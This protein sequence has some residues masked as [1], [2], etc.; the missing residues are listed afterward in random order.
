[1]SSSLPYK[2]PK[3]ARVHVQGEWQFIP[4]ILWPQ[5]YTAPNFER[6][7]I[8]GK[9]SAVRNLIVLFLIEAGLEKSKVAEFLE[10]SLA[11]VSTINRAMQVRLFGKNYKM[12]RV[13]IDKIIQ[14]CSSNPHADHMLELYLEKKKNYSL[15]R[16][17][18]ILAAL[19]RMGRT[20]EDEQLFHH[21]MEHLTKNGV[22]IVLDS[23]ENA[24]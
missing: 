19:S 16:M 21:A 14:Q 18:A 11:R 3:S 12:H 24:L 20:M 1:M 2:E 22:K 6:W 9:E 7:R 8:H 15:Y 23:Y 4:L 10:L 13:I 17:Q 5:E